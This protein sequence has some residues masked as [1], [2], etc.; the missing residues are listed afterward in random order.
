MEG[1]RRS[2]GKKREMIVD[3]VGD[4]S[5]RFAGEI[6]EWQIWKRQICECSQK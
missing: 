5:L 4:G 1:D 2:E 6:N 3:V